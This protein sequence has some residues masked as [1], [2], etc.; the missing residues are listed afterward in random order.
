MKINKSWLDEWVN[1]GLD[2]ESIG[3]RLTMAGLELDSTE[4]AA[5]DFSGVVVAHIIGITQHPDADKLRICRVSTGDEELQVICGAANA[6]QDLRVAL[7]TVGAVL[8]GGM[9]IKRARL[10]GVESFG[11]LCSDSELGLA[12]Q[13]EG[14]LE[15]PT[16]APIGTDIRVY[17]DL[18][19]DVMDIDLTPNR[20]DCLSVLGVARELAVLSGADLQEV[21]IHEHAPEINDQ[22]N[23]SGQAASASTLTLIWSLISNMR[24]K[25]M[26]RSMSA[27]RLMQLAR[28]TSDA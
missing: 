26:T 16:D 10:R 28:V 20:A 5:P 7:A 19:D 12:E 14:I 23:V 11:M 2:T 4:P 17:L 27:W 21:D 24:P 9:E 22:I 3:Q 18:N 8:P 15:L 6:R 13:S 25:L 1:T